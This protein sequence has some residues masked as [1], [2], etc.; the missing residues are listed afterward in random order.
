MK[1]TTVALVLLLTS[2]REV[3][4]VPPD[5]GESVPTFAIECKGEA[6]GS[7]VRYRYAEHDDCRYASA[8]VDGVSETARD[9]YEVEVDGLRLSAARGPWRLVVTMGQESVSV[10]DC[11][12]E[13]S[14]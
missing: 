14:E 8:A 5:C 10:R 6:F 2:C 1:T 11:T 3:L 7:H 4:P 12:V 9:R 13:G